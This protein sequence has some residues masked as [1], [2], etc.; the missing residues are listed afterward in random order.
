[1]GPAPLTLPVLLLAAGRGVR[2]DP[3]TRIVAKPA[4]PFG[5][6]TLIEHVLDRLVRQGFTEF[7]VNLHH[8]PHT[9][10]GVV[11]DGGQIGARV[12]YSWEQ[13]VVLGSAGGPRHALPLLD[14]DTFLIVNSDTLCDLDLA[15][16]I[17]EH[18]RTGA[19]VTLA[20]IPNPAPDRYGGVIVE[21]NGTVSGFTRK[22]D[23][24]ASWHFVGVQAANASIFSPLQDD[25]PAESVGGVYR[26]ALA[27]RPGCIRAWK[28]S[29]EFIDVGTPRDYFEAATGALTGPRVTVIWP[30]AS[31]DARAELDRCIVTTGV[32][33]P[34]GFRATDVM[35]L[36]S[37]FARDGDRCEIR[38]EIAVFPIRT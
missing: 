35:L 7:V 30:G 6:R 31:V 17:D 29:G 18:R 12:R 34:P 16:L 37:S 11:G 3:L 20:V 5:G 2:L 1:M 28:T 10:A 23:A 15:S 21:T 22:G 13:P 14:A 33:V 38:D 19:E 25:V 32:S 9:I 4:V 36:P 8:L 26:D 27:M 24:R